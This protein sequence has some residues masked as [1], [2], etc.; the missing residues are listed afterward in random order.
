M[1]LRE[2]LGCRVWDLIV[3]SDFCFQSSWLAG[4][5]L[6]QPRAMSMEPMKHVTRNLALA[7]LSDL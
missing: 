3:G 2:G 5:G 7:V 4:C 6:Q 1:F